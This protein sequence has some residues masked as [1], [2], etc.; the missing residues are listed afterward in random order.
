MIDKVQIKEELIR[1]NLY[2]LQRDLLKQRRIRIFVMSILLAALLLTVV[3]GTLENPFIYTFSNIGNFFDYRALFIVWAIV[4]GIAI[5]VS[6]QALFRLEEYQAKAKYTFA[7][8]SSVFL[9]LT[10]IIPA[11]KDIYPFWHFLHTAFAVIYALF[12][13]ITLVPFVNWV[14][15]ENPRLKLVLQIWMIVIWIGSLLPLIILG[16]S[17]LFEMWF[18][19]T[20]IMFMLYLSMILFEE[21]I[22]KMSVAFLKNET[23]LNEAIEKIFINLDKK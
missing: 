3:Y 16:K 9:I 13:L 2:D 21:K 1:N 7:A 14:S 15:R 8:L 22:V 5:Q 19:V 11:L 17:G 18:F 12:I 10:A 4:S 23:N 20:V 6:I